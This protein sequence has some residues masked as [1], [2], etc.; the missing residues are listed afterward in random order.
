MNRVFALVTAM[1][2]ALIFISGAWWWPV[3]L[4][5]A[6]TGWFYTFIMRRNPGVPYHIGGRRDKG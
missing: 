2:L 3:L 6:L 4:V 5:A 1:L